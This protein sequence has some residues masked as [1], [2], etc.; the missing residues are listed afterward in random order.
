MTMKTPRLPVSTGLAQLRA[1]GFLHR[2]TS[3]RC[4]LGRRIFN[5]RL[6]ALALPAL[7]AD[8]AQAGTH[9]WS[10]A[11]ADNLWS[12]PDNWSVGGPP[13]SGEVNSYLIFPAASGYVSVNNVANLNITRMTLQHDSYIFAASGGAKFTFVENAS[14]A[15]ISL[16]DNGYF[17]TFNS[18]AN[19]E[20]IGTNR[21]TINSPGYVSLN[22]VVSGIGNLEKNGDGILAF[23]G[24]APN[25]YTGFTAVNNGELRLGKT[26]GV[27]AIPGTLLIGSNVTAAVRSSKVVCYA[28][29]QIADTASLSIRAPGELNLGGFNESIGPLELL[30]GL[31]D[32]AGGLLTLLG[33][34]T[35]DGPTGSSATSRFEGVVSLGSQSRTFTVN[36]NGGYLIFLANLTGGLGA[37]FTK[38]GDGS[39]RLA[40][41]NSFSGTA[42]I[43][44]GYAL[45]GG[46]PG[47]ATATPFGTTNAGTVLKAGAH[48]YLQSLSIGDEPLTIEDLAPPWFDAQFISE[49]DCFWSGPITVTATDEAFIYNSGGT[50]TLSGPIGGPGNVRF[51]SYFTAQ[52]SSTILTG[53]LPN[54][55]A[56]HTYAEGNE[57]VLSKPDG[58]NAIPGS[59]TLEN[60]GTS[61]IVVTAVRLMHAQ[62]IADGAQVSVQSFGQLN[63]N[64]FAEAI[65]SLAGT[66]S[67]ATASAALTVGANNLNTTFDGT[68]TGNGPVTLVKQGTG[69]LTLTGS[70]TYLGRTDVTG[71]KLLVNGRLLS[72]TTVSGN[73]ALG[74][75]GS[76]GTVGSTDGFVS[77]GTSPGRLTTKDIALK[78]STLN[79]ELNGTTPGVNCDQLQTTG[80]VTLATSCALNVTLG[81]ASVVGDQ[82]TLIANDGSDPIIGT[83]AAF[84][85]GT[86]LML[87]GQKFVIS[88]IGGTGNDVVLTHS[89][90][91]PNLTSITNTPFASE[92]GTVSIDGIISDPDAADT[93]KFVVNWGDGSATETNNLPAGTTN[94]HVEHIYADDKPGV[95]PSDAFTINY[96]LTD[97]SGSP[98]FGQLNTLISNVAPSCPA[99]AAIRLKSGEALATA[100]PFTDPGADTWTATVDYG[101]G[102]GTQPLVVGPGR[103]LP[104]S[105]TF[106]TNGTYTVNLT[107]NDDDTGVGSGSVTVLVG[108]ELTITKRNATLSFVRWPGVFNGFTLES[109]PVLP[110]GTNWSPV[111]DAPLLVN[112][113]WQVTVPHTVGNG[114]FRLRKP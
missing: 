80:T 16:T 83:F 92:G 20:L 9:N 74:G 76:V 47:F 52:P 3:G 18:S 42:V 111:A 19:V 108:L 64:N 89:N 65:G 35:C 103:S 107:V 10:G 5:R 38:A 91:A 34:V 58:V 48:L 31:A 12:N 15:G 29:N 57:L 24:A 96:T 101:D 53:A 36:T 85:E 30:G 6:A 60:Y 54:T 41:T 79:V 84:V 86:A 37:G 59:L 63:L 11:G 46:M 33:D 28:A 55:Y 32:S 7:L 109:T 13:Y 106:P 39:M 2:A 87:N 90:T 69:A 8:T 71:G 23:G 81:F 17:V 112:D 26:A 113:Q 51:F 114:F 102:T 67:V 62:Q 110:G 95:F 78:S 56:G 4:R 105:H 43:A 25:T 94:F 98:A 45:V 97:I 40:G 27:N 49:G 1:R 61:G 99:Y 104:L 21:W 77:P 75:N 70:Q 68:I 44:A 66:G 72:H 14:N 93:F 73:A 100:L 82:F 88:Y 50:L 22:G